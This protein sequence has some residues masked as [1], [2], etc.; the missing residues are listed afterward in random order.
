M[1]RTSTTTARRTALV[2]PAGQATA[3]TDDEIDALVQRTAAQ[4]EAY[5][6]LGQLTD[7]AALGEQESDS[8]FAEKRDMDR[9]IG[10]SVGGTQ[11]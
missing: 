9:P 11:A 5:L 3:T 10:L 8:A 6:H 2:T 4:Y 7:L 1:H